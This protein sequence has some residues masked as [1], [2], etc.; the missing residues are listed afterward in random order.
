[1]R[2]KQPFIKTQQGREQVIESQLH[3]YSAGGKEDVVEGTN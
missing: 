1:M 2:N 3:S